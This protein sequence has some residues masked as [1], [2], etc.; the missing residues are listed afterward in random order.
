MLTEDAVLSCAA[1]SQVRITPLT[2]KRVEHSGIKVQLIGQ[3]ELASERGSPHDFVSLGE[4]VGAVGA[5]AAGV[6]QR[7]PWRAVQALLGCSA[8]SLFTPSAVSGR[9]PAPM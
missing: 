6:Q 5:R 7:R 4:G 2:T 3:I 1:L 8:R 9:V